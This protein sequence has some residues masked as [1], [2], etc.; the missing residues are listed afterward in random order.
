MAEK[1]SQ[2]KLSRRD[3]LL[4]T[5]SAALGMAVSSCQ[6][7]SKQTKTPTVAD[8]FLHKSEQTNQINK[9]TNTVEATESP[10]PSETPRPATIRE[11]ADALGVKIAIYLGSHRLHDAQFVNTALSIGNELIISDDLF[12]RYIYSDVNWRRILDNWE[13]VQEEFATGSIPYDDQ[14]KWDPW[15]RG[16]AGGLIDFAQKRNM[17]VVVDSLL[18]SEDVPES[19]LSGGFS[20]EELRK[21]AEFMVKSK[22]LKFK[23]LVREWSVISESVARN[24]WGD[25]KTAFWERKLGY[26]QIVFDAFIW[27]REVDPIGSLNLI[28]DTLDPT[29]DARS[30]ALNATLS[31]LVSL[32]ENNIPVDGISFENNFWIF[33]PP[34]QE[35]VKETIQYIQQLGYK[36][37]HAQSTV[38]ISDEWPIW[39]SRARTVQL[40]SDK[41]EAQARIYREIFEIYIETGSDF[42]FYGVTD[43]DSWYVH[44]G[45][46]N[47]DPYIIDKDFQPKLAYFAMLEVLQKHYEQHY[48]NDF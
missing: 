32:R 9:S 31:L 12:C 26:P 3:F 20:R 43:A 42:G 5:G 45:E 14:I 2:T 23:G 22:V 34:R 37:G 25:S 44:H 38:V 24:L 48:S 17:S 19:V 13:F 18:W 39:K 8:N 10:S 35:Q 33:A 36:I 40:V 28:E 21:I 1:K 6:I 30:Q 7:A 16:E 46:P 47:A 41:L 11:L 27:A 15:G 4:M 29:D